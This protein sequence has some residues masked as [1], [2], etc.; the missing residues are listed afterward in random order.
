MLRR[1]EREKQHT[2]HDSQ[3][4]K[5]T[6]SFQKILSVFLKSLKNMTNFRSNLNPFATEHQKSQDSKSIFHLK[7]NQ[8]KDYGAETLRR[9]FRPPSR[10][11]VVI[12]QRSQGLLAYHQTLASPNEALEIWHIDNIWMLPQGDVNG[13]EKAGGGLPLHCLVELDAFVHL[14]EE[15][16]QTTY[17]CCQRGTHRLQGPIR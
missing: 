1:I 6:F 10:W 11:R 14:G 17:Y 15:L 13:I 7:S 16:V 4:Q 5:K 12:R 9:Q 2:V 8:F 3:L